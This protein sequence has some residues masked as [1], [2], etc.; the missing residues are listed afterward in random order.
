MAVRSKTRSDFDRSNTGMA[1][2]NPA[3]GMDV[4]PRFSVLCSPVWVEALR[5]ADPP[6]K[7]SYQMS[8]NRFINF[9]S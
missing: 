5:L 4:C 7:E 6:S 9:R 1:G 8:K 3:P 2:S